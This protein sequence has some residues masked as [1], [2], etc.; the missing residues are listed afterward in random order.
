MESEAL[1]YVLASGKPR[2][3]GVCLKV[4]RIPKVFENVVC[5]MTEMIAMEE[6][7]EGARG[8]LVHKE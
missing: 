2:G 5:G 3:Y 7:D 1:G 6:R 8:V 4:W